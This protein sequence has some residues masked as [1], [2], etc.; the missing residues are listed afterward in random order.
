M[1]TTISSL[2]GL[3]MV[4]RFTVILAAVILLCCPRAD[5]AP[6]VKALLLLGDRDY[7][8]LNF[9]ENGIA[10][11]VTVDIVSAISRETGRQINIELTDWKIAQERVLR[12]EADGLIGMSVSEER[13]QLYDFSDPILTNE[14]SLFARNDDLRIR[15]VS[16]LAG[17]KV[18]VTRGGLP[19]AFME[20]RSEIRTIPVESYRA[21][22]ELLAAGD[23]DAFAGD[24]WVGA[25]TIQKHDLRGIKLAGTPFAALPGA[26]AIR[27]GNPELVAEINRAIARL[28]RAGT[29]TRIRDEWR[30]QEM[31]FLSQGQVK[32]IVVTAVSLVLLVLAVAMAI[33]IVSLKRQI[34]ERKKAEQALRESQAMLAQIL[35][36]VP[37]GIFWKDRNSV[38]RGCNKVLAKSLGFHSTGQV[39]GKTDF[40]LP[41]PREEA[42]AYRSDDREVIER[43][44]PKR[45]IEEPMQ[46]AD[47]TRLW[48]E[49]TKV[50]LADGVGN[51]F[52][53]LGVFDDIT[54][55]KQMQDLMVQAEKMTMIAGLA[56]GMAHEINN[57]LGIIVQNL[58][59]LERRFSPGFQKNIEIAEQVGIEFKRLHA[60]LDRQEVFDFISGMRD[61]GRRASK[62]MTNMLQ[63]SRKSEGLYQPVS[64]PVI[65]DQAIEMTESDYDLR[66]R[67]DFK[68][69]EIVRDYADDLPQISVNISE[70]EQVLINLLKNAAQALYEACAD[71]KPQIRISIRR[72]EELVEIKVAD[73][74]PG[75]TDDVKRRIFDPFFTTKEVGVG[76][77]LGL[78]VSY[79]II[80]KNHGGT[81][82]VES[83]PG[84]GSCFTIHLPITRQMS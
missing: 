78:A 18:A 23:V 60:Y 34:R 46:Q 80:T 8:P 36:S 16:N 28:E 38:Y 63:F 84:N 61:A 53:V 72:Q 71:G 43:N 29:I 31:F 13:K 30:P 45:H 7:P 4:V 77:G 55:R 81:I 74:G 27:K 42:E 82:E 3:N 1:K 25:Y 20:A 50:P 76:T 54:E 49:T 48:V 22:L 11:G 12:G 5:A 35:D 62:V 17:M 19:R 10:K 32:G 39:V 33:W 44:R 79:A 6:P 57:P 83:S 58:Q 51:V 66:K 69:I 2:A 52:G 64:L 21:G 59:V 56:A 75:M 67:Y 73:N 41:W 14:F 65:C 24:R 68:H 47:G 15:G 70:I 9:V 37:L 26:I 40:D